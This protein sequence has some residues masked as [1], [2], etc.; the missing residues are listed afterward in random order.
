[1]STSMT[2]AAST[3]SPDFQVFSTVRPVLRLRTR[4]RLNACPLP[5]LTISFSTMTKGTPSRRILRP[6]LNSLV[7]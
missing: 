4:T 1:M 5:G 7:L 6:D 3:E 2:S